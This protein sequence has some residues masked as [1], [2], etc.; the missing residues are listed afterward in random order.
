MESADTLKIQKKKKIRILQ[1][2]KNLTRQDFFE[3]VAFGQT[4][5]M[6][7]LASPVRRLIFYR[8]LRD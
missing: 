3:S 5:Y 2:K 7:I 6:F 4:K 8:Q 1:Q